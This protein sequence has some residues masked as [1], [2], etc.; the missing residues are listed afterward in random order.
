MIRLLLALVAL[1]LAVPASAQS[2]PTLSVASPDG[3]IVLTTGTTGEGRMV[4]SVTRNGRPLIAE[5]R[6][7]FLFTDALAFDRN[8][9]I[10]AHERSSA[11][12]RWELPWGERRYVRDHHNELAVTFRQQPLAGSRL[13]PAAREIIVR[14]RVFDDGIGFRYEFGPGW[15]TVNIQD[16]LTEFTLASD[17]A[18]EGTAWWIM[19][20]DWNRYEQTYQRTAID[21][22]STAHTPITM[23]L[24][25]GTHLSI[26]E[27]ALV[28]Y[29]GMWL[30]RAEGLRFRGTLS[31]SGS[32]PRV[33]RA[34][35]FPTPWRTVRIAGNAA[36]LVES[37][38]ELNLNEPNRLGDVS[39][40]V[41]YKYIGIWWDMHLDNWTWAQGPRHGATTEHS[42]RYIDFAARHG[43]RGVLVEGWNMGWD[44]NWFGTGD[45]F[46]FTQAT[47]DFDIEGLAAYARQRGV[48]LIGHHETGGNIANYEAQ[49][50]DAMALYGRLG[51][52]SVKTGYVADAGGVVA[53]SGEDGRLQMEWHDGQV[54]SRHHLRVVETAA[55]YHIAVNPHEPIKDTGLRRTYPNW[56]SREAAR[57]MEYNAWGEPG[58]GVDHEPTL[59]YTRMLSG[60]MDYTPGVLS[61]EGRGGRPMASTLA[62]QLALY[63]SL[64]SPI[65]MAADRIENLERFPRE[66]AFIAAVPTNWEDSRLIDGAV[67]EFA[68]FR[69]K[70]R[71]SA[72]WYVGGITNGEARSFDVALDFLE[73]GQRYTA[74]I[75]RDGPDADYRTAARGQ[76]VIDERVVTSADRL[77]FRMAPG[78][79]TAIRLTPL[80]R[81]RR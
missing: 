81:G 45:E 7:G 16:E 42:R 29:S 23:R 67:G 68:L 26:H 27:A 60:P 65:Q 62:R 56:V 46:S 52:D 37:D 48:R 11:D 5:S 61:L 44:G 8:V 24:A 78:G 53:G 15:G 25:D 30:R 63:L 39:W 80:R 51:I 64:Y 75:Y 33:T 2:S 76:I 58:N 57:G 43:F 77:A 73:P 72:D 70:D 12:S 66:L 14:F 31:P 32:G 3:S 69:R 10:A 55:H 59:I 4:Y 17:A 41:P 71:D 47:P 18:A 74:T 40:V 28:D 19:G 36:G 50:E 54:Q 38:L 35:P 79:G 49:L 1:V 9:A 20:G 22:V 6:L 13:I 21:A 34:A